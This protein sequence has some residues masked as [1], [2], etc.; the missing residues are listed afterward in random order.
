MGD[1]LDCWGAPC[2]PQ[3]SAFSQRAVSWALN[4]R[5][6]KSKRS[7]LRHIVD[8]W[9]WEARSWREQA[10]ITGSL[11]SASV[12]LPDFACCYTW[13]RTIGLIGNTVMSFT[14]KKD[15]LT[16]AAEVCERNEEIARTRNYQRS[17][18]KAWVP[19]SGRIEDMFPGSLEGRTMLTNGWVVNIRVASWGVLLCNNTTFT[20]TDFDMELVDCMVVKMNIGTRHWKIRKLL[21]GMALA[22]GPSYSLD[23]L[24]I[25]P[26]GYRRLKRIENARSLCL[27]V[28]WHPSF[29]KGNVWIRTGPI[30]SNAHVVIVWR[31]SDNFPWL[32]ETQELRTLYPLISR[33]GQ[34]WK[35]CVNGTHTHILPEVPVIF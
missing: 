18:Q 30:S 13:D 32:T 19:W 4:W 14:W 6:E 15:L 22:H 33:P 3:C 34:P 21:S 12:R 7:L 24:M 5:S 25:H 8:R 31:Q 1:L 29:L 16:V 35:V 11:I 9:Q 17:G 23:F 10:R 2:S 20:L 27:G 26:T 28:R